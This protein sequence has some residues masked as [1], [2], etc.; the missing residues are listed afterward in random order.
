MPPL[1]QRLRP[2]TLDEYV[3][4]THLLSPGKPLYELLTQG[5]EQ[6]F[7]LW[8]P[9][10]VG[11]TTLA[12]LYGQALQAEVHEVSAVQAGKKDLRQVIARA[13]EGHRVILFIDELHRF[14]K[15]QQDYLLPFVEEGTIIFI[16]S[17]TENPSFEVIAPLLSRCM[18]YPLERL[19]DQEMEVLLDRAQVTDTE[20]RDLLIRM[21]NGDGRRVFQ[22]IETVEQSTGQVTAA[23]IKEIGSSTH[24][25]YDKSG[26]EHYHTVSA[27]IKSMRASQP[28][29]ALYYLSR[30]LAGGEDPVFIARRLV[31]FSSEDV[32]MALPTAL[33]VANEVF[34][35]VETVGLPEAEINLAQGSVYM[36]E[37]PKDRRAYE[38]LRSAQADIKKYG[39]L[40][41]PEKI[42]NPVT[43]LMRQQGAG[44]G[45]TLYDTESFLP[46]KLKERTYY[47]ES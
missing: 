19:T 35:A 32:G 22:L 25:R 17:T 7:I 43:H 16:G 40:P 4:Q 36:A 2:Q 47:R 41:I 45:Y 9:P 12:R 18:V 29:A 46:E 21:S 5:K 15:A 34:R 26:D 39:N 20:A 44:K 27:W 33:V 30:M 11:K 31:I 6:S 37:A 10:G 23:A 3:G 42:K 1:A 13:Q 38:G 24:I 8:G 14:N 28:D